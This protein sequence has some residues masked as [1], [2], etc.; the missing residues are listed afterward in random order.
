MKNIKFSDNTQNAKLFKNTYW[1]QFEIGNEHNKFEDFEQIFKNRDIFV[2]E[3]NIVKNTEK[4]TNLINDYLKYLDSQI[5]NFDHSEV[6]KNI[7]GQYVIVISPYNIGQ[8]LEGFIKIYE[9][10]NNEATTY[11]KKITKEEMKNEM[12]KKTQKEFMKEFIERQK[13]K[14][15]TCELCKGSYTYFNKSTHI[16]TKR[17]LKFIG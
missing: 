3:Y 12:S 1:G 11:V 6:Y 17:H 9:L 5:L 4:K 14:K 8:E 15:Y 16:K 7:D 10:Y 2:N 13:D